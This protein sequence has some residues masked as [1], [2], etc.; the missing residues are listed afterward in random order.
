METYTIKK[1]NLKELESLASLFQE[2]GYK[3]KPDNR[4][5][6]F[7]VVYKQRILVL[8]EKSGFNNVTETELYGLG[9]NNYICMLKAHLEIM[10]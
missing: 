3:I 6:D 10:P 7:E 2:C 1:Q 9:L 5:F 4:S 8:F